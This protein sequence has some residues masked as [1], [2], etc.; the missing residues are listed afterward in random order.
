MLVL[1]PV[2]VPVDGR[3]RAPAVA[4]ATVA[5]AVAVGATG[6]RAPWSERVT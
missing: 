3:E 5:V 1:A 4:K 2:A 6:G